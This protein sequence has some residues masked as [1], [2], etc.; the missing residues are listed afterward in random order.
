MPIRLTALALTAALAA[1]SASAEEKIPVV[2]SFS[3]LGDIVREVGGDRIA[4][5]VLVGPDGDAHVFEPSP[6]DAQAVAAAKVLV[7]NGL[8]FE[9][10]M[11]RLTQASG[12]KGRLVTAAEGIT[13]LAMAEEEEHDH[14]G[15]GH[16]HDHDHHDHGGVDPHAWQ[17]LANGQRY[18]ETIA[19]GLC[20][21]DSAGCEGYKARAFAYIERLKALDSEIKAEIAAIPAERRKVV[22]SHDAFGYFASAYGVTFFAPV[23]VSTDSEASAKDVAAL[24]TQIKAEGI[25][26]VFVENVSDPRLVETIAAETGAKMGGKLYSD[27]LSG[28]DGPAATY[29]AMFRH[30]AAQLVSAL[31]P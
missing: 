4:L 2:A 27:A 13:P 20:E 29:E 12:F 21:A 24:I 6:S 9:G 26:A 15:H 19:R 23:G 8:K 3:I 14:H 16:G 7:V 28:P 18:A 17:D 25:A 5:T 11:D 30:N 1:A 10:W 31:R 22:T